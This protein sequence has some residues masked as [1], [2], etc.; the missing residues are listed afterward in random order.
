[1]V[2]SLG[3][4]LVVL[5]LTP[6]LLTCRPTMQMR[7][8]ALPGKEVRDDN[9]KPHRKRAVSMTEKEHTIKRREAALIHADRHQMAAIWRERLEQM[10]VQVN[11]AGYSGESSSPDEYTLS[12]GTL[13]AVGP[14]LDFAILEFVE[15]LLA[16]R[17]EP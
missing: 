5:L 14:T 1:M 8:D 17:S 3:G 7:E 16:E 10:G 9:Q 13:R 4:Q 2:T 12:Y 15:K 6:L 11:V